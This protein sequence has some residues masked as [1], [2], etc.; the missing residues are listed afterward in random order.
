[1]EERLKG[2]HLCHLSWNYQD[3]HVVFVTLIEVSWP[4]VHKAF[5]IIAESTQ[6]WTF[7]EPFSVLL[8]FIFLL[9]Q[10]LLSFFLSSLSFPSIFFPFL[11]FPFLLLSFLFPSFSFPF[12]YF[13]FWTSHF[14]LYI[15]TFAFKHKWQGTDPSIL[16]YPW[17]NFM[18][19]SN[20][21]TS[22]TEGWLGAPTGMRAHVLNWIMRCANGARPHLLLLFKVWENGEILRSAVLLCERLHL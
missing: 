10:L 2:M 18:P 1:M 12:Q 5:K 20:C 6:N 7:S 11:S 3:C 13:N 21:H 8:L 19:P 4:S 17:Q 22:S 16:V 9:T 14:Y 15:I